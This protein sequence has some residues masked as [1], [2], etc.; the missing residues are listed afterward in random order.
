MSKTKPG[1][2]LSIGVLVLVASVLL[3]NLFG[4]VGF[5]LA[6]VIAVLAALWLLPP[7]ITGWKRNGN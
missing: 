7:E 6:I 3:V 1:Q 5:V 4:G 2:A